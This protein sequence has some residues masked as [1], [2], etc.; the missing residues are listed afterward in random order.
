MVSQR[1]VLNFGIITREIEMS[2]DSWSIRNC[3]VG[4]CWETQ[5]QGAM[6]SERKMIHESKV[7]LS[8][9]KGLPMKYV[10]IQSLHACG[11][12]LSGVR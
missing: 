11:G 10:C 4:S 7:S 12:S 3:K 2:L 1:K 6:L 5:L 8:T 9:Y